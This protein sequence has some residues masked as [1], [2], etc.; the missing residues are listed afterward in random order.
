MSVKYTFVSTDGKCDIVT[1]SRDLLQ[2]CTLTAE[3]FEQVFFNEARTSTTYVEAYEKVEAWH[4]EMFNKRKY[5]DYN[6]FRNSKTQR[7]KKE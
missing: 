7:M 4:E 3:G 5:S 6:S 1:V 2:N